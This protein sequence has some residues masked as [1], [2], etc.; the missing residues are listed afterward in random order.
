MIF[1]KPY[2]GSPSTHVRYRVRRV[3]R[4]VQIPFI[5]LVHVLLRQERS[6][7]T[8]AAAIFVLSGLFHVKVEF[9]TRFLHQDHE[10]GAA[11][12]IILHLFCRGMTP[13]PVS[14]L[15]SLCTSARLQKRERE[16]PARTA[17]IVS[18][19]VQ[20]LRGRIFTPIETHPNCANCHFSPFSVYTPSNA[21]SY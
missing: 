21:N 9:D 13:A 4:L 10:L 8:K 3:N 12:T 18:E 6:V 16:R 14:L 7:K 1:S 2:M 5:F 19:V 17:E 11:S 20:S 15:F